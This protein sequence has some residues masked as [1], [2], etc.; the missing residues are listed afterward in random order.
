MSFDVSSTSC[1]AFNLPYSLGLWSDS[2]SAFKQGVISLW[3]MVWNLA[4][5][6]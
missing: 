3:L 1:T 2:T 6:G 4:V 5:L